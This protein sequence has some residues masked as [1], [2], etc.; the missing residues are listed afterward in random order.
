LIVAG[1]KSQIPWI[2]RALPAR[3]GQSAVLAAVSIA[4]RDAG[5][6]LVMNQNIKKA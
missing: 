5:A 3:L 1:L 6:M 4:D 2:R